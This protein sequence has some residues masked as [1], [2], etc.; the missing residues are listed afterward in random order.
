MRQN[1]AFVGFGIVA[2]IAM[3]III[4]GLLS[5]PS[6]EEFNSRRQFTAQ[7]VSF[8]TVLISDCLPRGW[9]APAPLFQ[10]SLDHKVVLND[11]H[12]D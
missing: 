11:E 9:S 5:L 7:V 8:E 2:V 3:F 6:D 12:V 1:W 4:A 10:V